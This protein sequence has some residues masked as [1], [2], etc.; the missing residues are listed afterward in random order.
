MKLFSSVFFSLIFTAFVYSQ[1]AEIV[2]YKSVKA[3]VKITSEAE[4]IEGSVNYRF[5]ML[6]DADSIYLDG[7]NMK[8][9]AINDPKL[10]AKIK[11]DSDKI[12]IIADF[13]ANQEYQIEF[14]YEVTKPKHAVYFVGWK[15]SGR[16]QVWTQG[17]GK[18]NSHWLPSIDDPNDKI[19]FDITYEFPKDY[20]LVGN[21]RLVKKSDKEENTVWR[22]QMK[23]PMSSYLLAFAAGKFKSENIQSTSGVDLELYFHPDDSLK[24]E[25]TYRY[26]KEIFDF[27]EEEIGVEYPWKN[28]KQ[29]P[30]WDFLY[31]GM[32]NT[33]VT[34]FSEAF[35]TDSIGFLDKN[36]VSVNAHELAHQWFG[37]SITAKSSESHW[38][39]EG[40]ASYYALLAEREI[41]GEDEYYFQLFESAEKLKSESDQGKGESLLNPKAGSLTFYEKGAWAVHILREQLGD[42][43]FKKGIQS[44]LKKYQYKSVDVDQ[45]IEEME[46]SSGQDL[47]EFVDNWLLQSAFPSEEALNSLK[48]S[49]FITEYMSITALHP[50]DPDEKAALLNKALDF[51]ANKFIGQQVVYQLA[52]FPESKERMDLYRKAFA[53]NNSIIRQAIASS[54]DKIL[55]EL[56]TEYESLLQDDSYLTRERAL[57]NLWN[58]FP[59]DQERYLE[60]TKNQQG[61]YDKNLRMLWLT[62]SLVTQEY[63]PDKNTEFYEELAGYTSTSHDYS[64]RQN[65]FGF[66]YQIDVFSDQNYRDLITAGLHPVWRFRNFAGA[67]LRDLL[68]E[69]HHRKKLENLMPRLNQEEKGFLEKQ[70]AREE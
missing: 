58:N 15:N 63:H 55:D 43:S 60:T 57:F 46:K 12:W 51:P 56:K 54:L 11:S 27:L 13:K 20:T 32:E 45:F 40:F 33:T 26:S 70:L 7:K 29:V 38:L 24:V 3:H 28:Y 49:D 19:I 59:E 1:Q 14:S 37:N 41:F 35:M 16:N 67:L 23:H 30:V 4:K 31:A 68:K 36:Y 61:F 2:D 8:V 66:L 21:G 50:I 53:T 47:S 64:I 48:K 18:D 34:L 65:A 25:P 17:Q 69:P 22:Y 10:K 42:S 9:T 39:Q 6:S 5:S 52:D 62:L 44:F